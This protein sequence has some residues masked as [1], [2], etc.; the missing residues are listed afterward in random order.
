MYDTGSNYL[1][2]PDKACTTCGNDALFDPAQSTSFSSLPG[3]G[4]YT[5]LEYSTAATS[6]PISDNDAANCTIVTDVVRLH[7]LK[8]PEQTFYLCNLY[9][10]SF[11]NVPMDGI[12]GL[13]I[14]PRGNDDNST[15]PSFWSW[16]S[17]GLLP[18]PVFSFYL[19][20]GAEVGAELTLGGIDHSKYTGDIA[21]VNLNEKI[22][23]LTHLFVVDITTLFVD[24]QEIRVSGNYTGMG[25][26]QAPLKPGLAAL[27]TGTAF[28]QAR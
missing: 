16:Y 19:I 3:S 25:Q 17:H 4:E 6:V 1:V 2:L 9:P 5:L 11:E 23:S 14:S 22:S 18:E 15:T 21:Y 27:D 7:G 12:L 28:L 13:G 10:S 8:S 26:V 24:D 20:P